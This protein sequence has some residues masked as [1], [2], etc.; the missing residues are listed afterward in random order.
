MRMPIPPGIGPSYAI[1]GSSGPTT[2]GA[3]DAEVEPESVEA[4]PGSEEAEGE[5]EELSAATDGSVVAEAPAELA[6][7]EHAARVSAITHRPADD[8]HW[9]GVDRRPAPGRIDRLVDD[10]VIALSCP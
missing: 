7:G 5:E 6:D 1:Q 2:T 9:P 3:G 8:H 4:T 10:V